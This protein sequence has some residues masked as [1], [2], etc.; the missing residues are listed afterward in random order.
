[1]PSASWVV[2]GVLVVCTMVTA[3]IDTVRTTIDQSTVVVSS[4]FSDIVVA[5]ASTARYAEYVLG[6]GLADVSGVGLADLA[7]SVS[8][9]GTRAWISDPRPSRHSEFDVNGGLF[10]RA[11]AWPLLAESGASTCACRAEWEA[12]CN[13]SA[14]E[15]PQGMRCITCS[16][17]CEVQFGQRLTAMLDPVV[18]AVAPTT[19]LF[20]A[21]YWARGNGTYQDWNRLWVV[22]QGAANYSLAYTGTTMADMLEGNATVWFAYPRRTPF[23]RRPRWQPPYIDEITLLPVT[24]I[25]VPAYT[26]SGQWLGSM[27]ADMLM[28]NSRYILSNLTPAFDIECVMSMTD[29]DIVSASSNA[30]DA[31]FP[32]KCVGVICNI[33]ALVP[34]SADMMASDWLPD[35]YRTVTLERS[36]GSEY[37]LFLHHA[38]NSEWLLW[39]FVPKDEAFPPNNSPMVISLSVCIPVVFLVAAFALVITLVTRHLRGQVVEMEQRLGSMASTLGTAAEDVI[40][41]LLRFK[42]RRGLSKKERGDLVDVIALIATN[43]IFSSDTRKLKQRLGAMQLD[44]DVDAYLLDVLAQD[45]RQQLTLQNAAANSTTL[46]MWEF[47]VEAIEVPQGVSILEAVAF[48]VID[49][50]SLVDYF[51]ISRKKLRRFLRTLEKGYKEVPYHASV[52]AADVTQAMYSLMCGCVMQFTPL[53]MLAAALAAAIHDYNHPGL[54][55]NFMCATLDPL[56]FRYNGLSVLESMHVAKAFKIL[57]AKDCNFL[58]AKLSHD[59]TVELH[60]MV[61]QLVLYTDMAKHLETT[62]QFSARVASGNLDSSSK[63]DRLLCLQVLLKALG[64]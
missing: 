64:R 53:E 58:S 4:V 28:A 41:T 25:E 60:R 44:S 42:N 5:I 63:A 55:N 34:Q 27:Y 26:K 46:V 24:T 47:D 49:A 21:W 31:L 51:S 10:A 2:V 57:L 29:G 39:Y 14:P 40:K 15:L 59:D 17:A 37:L 12:F 18:Q 7:L 13:R 9:D 33:F 43:K 38:R 52:H 32:G 54:N 36:S 3:P 8:L 23:D 30:F 35:D 48:S 20:T 50:M 62:S 6:M 16:V 61:V 1:M 56:F 45:G 11:T 19:P 22:S